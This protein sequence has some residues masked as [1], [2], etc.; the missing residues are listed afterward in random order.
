MLKNLFK[1]K[2][3]KHYRQ[4]IRE[5]YAREA[6]EFLGTDFK[7]IQTANQVMNFRSG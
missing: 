1:K 5:C 7:K 3:I 2:V 4:V 6:V